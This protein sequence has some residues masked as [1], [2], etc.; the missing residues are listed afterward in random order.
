MNACPRPLAALALTLL[1]TFAAAAQPPMPDVD[2]RGDYIR[3]HYSK[4]EAR[5]AM[6]DGVRLFTSIYVPNEMGAETWPI[7]LVRTPYSVG[8]Y[9]ADQYKTRLGSFAEY[10]KEQ[11]IFVFQDV[12]GAYMSE[13]E[14]VNMRP[15]I[16]RKGAKDFDESTDTWDTIEWLVKNVPRN[17]GK[18]GLWGIS[19]PGFYA[20]A[21][22]IDAHPAL[23][24]VSPQA[25]IAD[26]FWDDMHRHGAFTLSLS[27]GFFATFGQPRPEPTT[28]NA[29]SFEFE[30]GDGY[31]FY[32]D[33]GPLKNADEKYLKGKVGFW[34]DI[35]AH[36]NYD[37]FWQ[38]RNLLPHLRKIRPATLVVGG[39]FDMEDLYGPLKIYREIEKQDTAGANSLV[40][41]PWRHGGW[42]RTT[43]DRLGKTEFGFPTSTW[44]QQEVELA[45]FKHYLKGGPKPS[46]PEALVFETGANRWRSFDA[47]PPKEAKPRKLY[48]GEGFTLGFEPP[49][50]ADG[51]DA[52]DSYP[53]DPAKPVPYTADI[54]VG[55]NAEYMAE[56]QRFAAWRPD[57]L[58][59]RS[60]VLEED[61]TLAGPL[62][63]DLWVATT[64]GDADFVVKL[65]DLY[66][67]ELPGA[68]DTKEDKARVALGN[69]H[70]LVRGEAFRG[71]FRDSYSKPVPF[72]PNEP[73]RVAFELQDVLHTFKRGH[74]I[75]V[76]V[77]SSWFP[78]IDRNPQSW[79]P[80]I[81]E[82]E[83]K[84]FVKATHT[85]FRSPARSSALEVGVLP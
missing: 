36:P 39:F 20:A 9:G 78:L 62:K 24:A 59:Y 38:S 10:E 64:G 21:G 11:F 31:Q 58:T 60:A 77:Q 29:E 49:K 47:W 79:V 42:S 5:I 23:K 1:S 65:I 7:L 73:A 51:A 76:Q 74:R 4:F 27:F 25:P 46:L 17:N 32:L 54:N 8:P 40:M 28:E 22:A 48:L 19:Y 61:V 75:V 13:G 71:R 56:D 15:Q 80:N 84:D 45:F 67:G 2:E 35:V 3:A 55:W 69:M 30:T 34:Q 57:V 85:V 63:A 82:A 70:Q 12:R 52:A 44:Y 37:E 68:K 33:M 81:F 72:T 14:F 50:A 66:P 53:S 6:R 43:G 83:A 18:V 16:A 41:G 26:W